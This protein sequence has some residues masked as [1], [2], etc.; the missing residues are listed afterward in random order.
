MYKKFKEIDMFPPRSRFEGEIPKPFDNPLLRNVRVVIDCTEVFVENSSDTKE[1]GNLFSSY[2]HH[3]TVKILIGVA[4]CGAA[5]FVSEAFE[6]S[7]SDREIVK[8]SGF[9]NHIMKGDVIL[10]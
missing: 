1:A 2:K 6:G 7:I 8:Q 4:P 10:A 5:M 3:T 9:M